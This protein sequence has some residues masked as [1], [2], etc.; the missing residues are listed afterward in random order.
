MRKLEIYTKNWNLKLYRK[1]NSE[2]NDFPVFVHISR[3]A[4]T[5]IGECLKQAN[6]KVDNVLH[7]PIKFIKNYKERRFKDKFFSFAIVRN[8]YERFYSACKYAG[9]K[10]PK[11]IENISIALVKSVGINWISD[12]SI[13]HYE[14]FMSQKHFI[15]DLM[16]K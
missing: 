8:P 3:T 4:G 6:V 16:V 12:Y 9:Y 1:E 15:T 7:C 13:F 5:Y 10:D 11:D 2:Y 14:H